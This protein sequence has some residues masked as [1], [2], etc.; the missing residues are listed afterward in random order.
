MAVT[1]KSVH[2]YLTKR[3]SEVLEELKIEL[4]NSTSDIFKRALN[5]YYKEIFKDEY[6]GN[7]SNN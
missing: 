2:V 4:K 6:H 5:V 1:Y 7:T 3:D